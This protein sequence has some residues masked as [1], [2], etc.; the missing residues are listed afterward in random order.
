MVSHSGWAALAGAPSLGDMERGACSHWQQHRA[1][2]SYKKSTELNRYFLI[3]SVGMD[4]YSLHSS[5][6]RVLDFLQGVDAE[7]AQRAAARYHCFDRY[8]EDAMAYAYATAFSSKASCA[9]A[10]VATL[11]EVLERSAVHA[12]I[13]DGEVGHERAF[14]AACNAAVVAGA[15][16]YY[17]NMFFGD[18]LTWNLRDTHFAD[19]IGRLVA[20]IDSRMARAAG[21]PRSLRA[22]IVVWA[23]NSHLGDASATDMGQRRGEINL[24]QLMRQ[25][26][27]VNEVS[28]LTAA[29]LL[30]L[31][32]HLPLLKQ[33]HWATSFSP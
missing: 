22:K 17:R 10:A 31:R 19:T 28:W 18:E 30:H 1:P 2:I 25:R 6:K 15:E 20:H 7:A 29:G 21:G 32:N 9:D 23:H 4:L 27:G 16:E 12:E 14:Q 3:Q 8:G 24:G 26:W 11:R 13:A 5:A 33:L